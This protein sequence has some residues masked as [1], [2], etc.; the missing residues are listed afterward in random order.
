MA[1]Q[2]QAQVEDPSGDAGDR[3]TPR[4]LPE[5]TGEEWRRRN[6]SALLHAGDVFAS[7]IL[8]EPYIT[9]VRMETKVLDNGSAYARIR[10]QDGHHS[11]QFL[12]VRPNHERN[13]ETLDG[14]SRGDF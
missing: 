9:A 2:H 10:S 5:C 12:T 4:G 7:V 11:V 8:G 3:G 14:E 1:D 6:R 13:R